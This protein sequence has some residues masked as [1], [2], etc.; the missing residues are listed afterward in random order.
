MRWKAWWAHRL[1][2]WRSK[3]E[4]EPEIVPSAGVEVSSYHISSQDVQGSMEMGGEEAAWI[5]LSVFP[6]ERAKRVEVYPQKEVGFT[7]LS[8]DWLICSCISA[9][10]VCLALPGPG[11]QCFHNSGQSRLGRLGWAEGG[12][13]VDPLLGWTQLLINLRSR[14]DTADGALSK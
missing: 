6:F 12:I 5:F 14:E 3:W 8:A 1:Q 10:L 4:V 7:L 9:F 11:T 13:S 2:A